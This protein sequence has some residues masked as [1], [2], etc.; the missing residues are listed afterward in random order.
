MRNWLQYVAG[1]FVL[2]S[3]LAAAPSTYAQSNSFG[4]YE[5]DGNTM[6]LLH[7]DGDSQADHLTN[8]SDSSGDANMHGNVQFQSHESLGD[9]G[10][11]SEMGDLLYLDNNAIEDSSY[12]WVPDTSGLDLQ[13][14]W[15][16]EAWVNIF[17]YGQTG[18]D[19]RWRPKLLVKSG[20][21]DGRAFSNY[22]NVMRGDLQLFH[23]GYYTPG[24]GWLAVDS[25][26]NS[27]KPT[28]WYH[29]TFVRDAENMILMQMIHN[30]QGELVYFNAGAI[31]PQNDPPNE[32]DAPAWIGINLGQGGGWLDGYIDEMRVSDIVRDFDY[33]PALTSASQLP[34]QPANA[35]SEVRTSLLAV[36]NT[37]VQSAQVHYRTDSEGDGF[38]GSFQT[39]EMSPDTAN[40]YVGSIPG[41]QPGTFVQYYISAEAENGLRST[42]PTGVEQTEDPS[43]YSYT[44]LDTTSQTLHLAFENDEV[45]DSSQY[46]LPVDV[47]G[48]PTFVEG[49][50]EAE[51][52]SAIFLRDSSYLEI[53]PPHASFLNA[54]SFALDFWFAAADSLPGFGTRMVIKESLPAQNWN[55]FNYQIW[56][57]GGGDVTAASFAPPSGRT[58]G[59]TGA[60]DTTIT[61]DEWYRIEYVFRADQDTAFSRLYDADNELISS[62][63]GVVTGD[64]N[65]SAGPFRVGAYTPA[66]QGTPTDFFS[67]MVDEMKFYNYVPDNYRA[68]GTP[69]EKPDRMPVKVTMDRNYPNPFSETT[70]IS[71]ALSQTGD[72]TL[73][74]YDVLGRKVATLVDN[75][76]Q[77]GR[78]EV[79]FD[80]SG[81]A[82][83]VYFYRLQTENVTK[84]RRMVVVK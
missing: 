2:G 34:N 71:Y 80:A 65:L 6:M 25:P 84:V 1:I 14:S 40:T 49:A 9:R 37:N 56:S 20:P 77:A 16:M 36:G 81:L 55:D 46:D 27:F 39:A 4:P 76:V 23:T 44:V 72:A 73:T 74:V 75:L 21:S 13:E 18:E 57:T 79:R 38:D 15:T 64:P 47:G 62:S 33:P 41:Q 22:F 29:V 43:Y 54:E 58:G 42:S 60:L 53:A 61:P 63:G 68:E 32:T 70:T 5:N 45:V 17:T 69:V 66:I 11:G 59:V 48:D 24:A 7:F 67:G 28:N 10:L 50:P 35:P 19:H 78:H 3:L 51:G 31:P 30:P 83:G 26:P 52:E 12:L 8:A 82:S